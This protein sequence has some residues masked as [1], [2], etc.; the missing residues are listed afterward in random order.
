MKSE[1]E[2]VR[3]VIAV[4]KYMVFLVA[5]FVCALATLAFYARFAQL[6]PGGDDE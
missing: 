4:D 2:N 6:F 5:A 1:V 3:Y